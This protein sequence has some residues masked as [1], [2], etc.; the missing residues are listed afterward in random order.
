M[1]R[2]TVRA[3][4]AESDLELVGETDLGDDLR[5]TVEGQGAQVVVDFTQPDCAHSNTLEILES[6]ACPVVGTTGFEPHE[7]EEL[8]ER[9][10]GLGRGGVIAPNFALGAVLLMRFSAE[11]ARYF[12][13]V[14]VIELHH[15]RKIDAPSGTAMRTVELIRASLDARRLPN[16]ASAAAAA[17]EKAEEKAEA[18]ADARPEERETVPGA[19][20]GRYL[21]IPVHSVR[22]PG[23]V[24]HQEVHFGGPGQILTLRH[25]APARS[26]F[27]PGV[28]LAVRKAPKLDRLYYGLDEILDR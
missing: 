20:G 21:G 3:V 7:I 14:E 18:G 24:A 1:G 5:A 28:L 12:P 2:E 27:M 8:Q 17:E 25:D 16:E 26:C 9:A 11:A 23:Y 22:L 4:R 13:D 6:G 15:E 10:A 19:R